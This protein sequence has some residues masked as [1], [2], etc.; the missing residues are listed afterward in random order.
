MLST[1]NRK[2]LMPGGL[3]KFNYILNINIITLYL[4]NNIMDA[5]VQIWSYYTYK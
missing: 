4:H 3:L 2:A 5:I 1:M